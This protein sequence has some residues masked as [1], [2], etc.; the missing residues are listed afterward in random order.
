MNSTRI[1]EIYEQR[2]SF[3][4]MMESPDNLPQ[5]LQMDK[6]I[7]ADEAE[8]RRYALD[9]YSEAQH[10]IEGIYG[11]PKGAVAKRIADIKAMQ[12]KADNGDTLA[13]A[14]LGREYYF[15]FFIERR[16]DIAVE[17][18]EKAKEKNSV[19]MY[20]LGEIY[21]LENEYPDYSFE[22]AKEYMG[23]AIEAGPDKD[24]YIGGVVDFEKAKEAYESIAKKLSHM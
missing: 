18:F 3:M 1:R 9:G 2:L 12:Q 21:S 20:Y 10:A 14:E 7:K 17:L 6:K 19:A 8:L 11:L 15:G 24:G 22:K 5:L 13:M 23:K 4:K 16:L